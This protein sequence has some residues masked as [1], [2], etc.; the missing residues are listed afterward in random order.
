MY[1]CAKVSDLLELEI[2]IGLRW[3]WEL[4][5]V[6]CRAASALHLCALSLALTCIS[7]TS[8]I[9]LKLCW[10]PSWRNTLRNVW[11]QANI[12]L[13]WGD[14]YT[15]AFLVSGLLEQLYCLKFMEGLKWNLWS[16]VV[17]AHMFNSSTWLAE[18]GELLSYTETEKKK[19][20]R[21]LWKVEWLNWG[22]TVPFWS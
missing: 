2:Q 11:P 6:L 17:V 19:K 5:W 12:E 3:C 7:Y 18:A 1:V 21:N 9:L 8:F 4:N 13:L 15:L 20:D 10:L 22:K 14:P 16:W